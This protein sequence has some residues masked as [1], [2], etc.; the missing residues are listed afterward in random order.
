[1]NIV[2][3]AHS[4]QH[5]TDKGKQYKYDAIECMIRYTGGEG[6]GDIAIIKVA[7]F[8]NPGQMIDA[9]DAKYLV[10]PGIKSPMGANLSALSDLTRTKE[11]QAEYG[12]EIFDWNGI[13]SK[14][15][16]R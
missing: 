2:D 3:K 1:M 14:I 7:D 4:A 5:V 12:G 13:R 11:L 15:L 6:E 10:S 9:A 16:S 8:G